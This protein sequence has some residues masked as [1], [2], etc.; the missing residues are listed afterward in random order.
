MSLQKGLDFGMKMHF[1]V[2]CHNRREKTIASLE[3]LKMAASRGKVEFDITVYDDGSSDGTASSL[4]ESFS[5]VTVINGTGSEFWAKSMFLAERSVL[6][7]AEV[8]NSGYIVWLN[9]DVL[10]DEDSLKRL[11][12]ILGDFP[13]AIIIGA[14]RD[15]ENSA[16]SYSGLNK[17]GRHPLNYRI[18]QPDATDVIEVDSFNGNLVLVPVNV[19]RMVGGIDG[20]FTHA[21]ADIDYGI[22]SAKAGVRSLLAPGTYGRCDR[23]LPAPIASMRVEWNR[24]VGVKGPGN[25]TSTA[26]LLK[27]VVPVLW[28]LFWT[29]TYVLWWLRAVRRHVK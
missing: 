3:S 14:M 4:K 8:L 27:R 20:G 25:P 7:R 17:G 24:F 11:F 15:F 9:D 5:N 6:E 21:F 18:V 10:L 26:R 19:A 1:I 13:D 16:V 29:S 28:P 22:R 2:A 23:N 12:K